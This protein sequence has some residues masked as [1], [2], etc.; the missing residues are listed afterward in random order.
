VP[1]LKNFVSPLKKLHGLNSSYAVSFSTLVLESL[2]DRL[3]EVISE[4]LGFSL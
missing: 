3:L 1:T 2:P 4:F